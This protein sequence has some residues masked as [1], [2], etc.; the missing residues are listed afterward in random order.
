MPL[1]PGAGPLLVLA[2]IL[3]AGMSLGWLAQRLRLPGVTGQVLAG[4]IMGRLGLH[5]FEEAAVE[6]LQ[7]LTHFALAL[8]GVTVGAHLNLRRLRNAGRRLLLLLLA[9]ATITPLVTVSA[10]LLLTDIPVTMAFLLATLAISTAPATVVAIIR[11]TRSRGTFVKTLLAAVAINNMVC[12]VLFEL[13]RGATRQ[14]FAAGGSVGAALVPE[15]YEALLGGV[16]QLG[17]AASLGG[18]A[19]VATHLLTVRVARP[20]RLTTLSVISIMATIGL[21]TYSG[22][23]PLLACMVLGV[24][25]TNLNPN[26]DRLVDSVFAN[27]EPAILCTF[28]ALA[29]LHLSFEHAGRVGLLAAVF[30]AARIF[31][32]LLSAEVSMRL[33]RATERVRRNLGI[34]LIPQAGVAIGLVL[35]IQDDPAFASV[36]ELFLAVVLTAVTLA[37]VVGPV[38][39]RIGLT[40]SGEVGQDRPHLVDFIQEENIVTEL[41]ADS[42]EHAI[43]QLTDL[44]LSSHHLQQV[45]RESMLRSV[46]ER[47]AQVSTCLG[48]G[49]AVPHGELP[50]GFSMVGVMGISRRGLHVETPDDLPLHCIVLLATP[51]GERDR[52]LE[53]LAAL[54]RTVAADSALQQELYSATSPAHA[55]EVLQGERAADFN[56]LLEEPGDPGSR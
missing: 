30:F 22:L 15:V 35:L 29:G 33:A 32:K 37:E 17:L 56:Y 11:E 9:E 2:V 55:Y 16:W 7:P 54:A 42:M 28:F 14:P 34:A 50:E 3:V 24:V 5:L 38:A 26:R 36:H 18:L 49:L 4:I 52:H 53:V 27:F 1:T 41:E 19:A 23:S 20:D 45:D 51:R 48:S 6:E 21:S 13:V 10:L 43:E 40:R 31:G 25:Q 12:I 46:L 39:T 8:I 47:E 44:L